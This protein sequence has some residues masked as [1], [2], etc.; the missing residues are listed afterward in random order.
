MKMPFSF[1]TRVAFFFDKLLQ[2]TNIHIFV[3]MIIYILAY[4]CCAISGIPAGRMT[5]PEIL[6]GPMICQ[7]IQAEDLWK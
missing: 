4:I 6:A 3:Q 7:E 1:T 5:F 2:Q